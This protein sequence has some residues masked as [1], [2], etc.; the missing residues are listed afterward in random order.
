MVIAKIWSVVCR[1]PFWPIFRSRLGGGQV[2][3]FRGLAFVSG[4][5]RT[6]V[7]LYRV[8]QIGDCVRVRNELSFPT[9]H[10]TPSHDHHSL[11]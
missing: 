2:R 10:H 6:R 11:H 7:T 3:N 8:R 5:W 1:V 9:S 4:V